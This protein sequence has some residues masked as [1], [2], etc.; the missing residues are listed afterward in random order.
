ME[1]RALTPELAGDFFA[2]FDHR[3]FADNPYWKGCYCT[4]FHRPERITEEE[5]KQRPTRRE[6][7]RTL[8]Q[9]G[10]LKGYLAYG[11]EGSVLGWCN[12][13]RKTEF[14]R[15]GTTSPAEAGVVSVVCFV[16]D[17]A[18]R[19]RGIARA[20]LERVIQDAT[21]LGFRWVEA[22]PSSRAKSES[23]HYHGPVTLYLALGFKKILGRKQV[24][25]KALGPAMET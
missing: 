2:F 22:Y 4:F 11:D 1:I 25:R 19:R 23:G 16:V 14:A 6:Q 3:A 7:A 20:L 5:R 9:D 21:D 13:N 15:L 12:A 18:H 10:V 24:V 17:P 8:I